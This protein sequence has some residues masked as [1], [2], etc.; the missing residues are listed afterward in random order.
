MNEPPLYRI[1]E[2]KASV[3]VLQKEDL[4]PQVRGSVA[5]IGHQLEALENQIK[6]DAWN[7]EIMAQCNPCRGG[8]RVDPRKSGVLGFIQAAD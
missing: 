8:R 2:L 6:M 7:E 4:L 5:R 1:A 3:W